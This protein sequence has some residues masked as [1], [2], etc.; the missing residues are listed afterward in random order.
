MAMVVT[1]AVGLLVAGC[2]GSTSPAP[3]G[4]MPATPTR[5][6]S[7]S[8]AAHRT[9]RFGGGLWRNMADVSRRPV[10]HRCGAGCGI[11]SACKGRKAVKAVKAWTVDLSGVV[12]GQPVVADGRIFAATENNR[13]VA[14][15]PGDGRVQWSVSLGAPLTDVDAVAGCG[16]IDP[17]G[18]T[19]TPVVDTRSHVVYVVGEVK[20]NDEGGVHHQL[21]GLDT[22]HR[23]GRRLGKCR[24]PAAGRRTCRQPAAAHL[25]RTRQR[26]GL[27]R[28]RRQYRRL[29]PLP[30]LAGRS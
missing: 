2:A 7:A 30:R 22:S 11:R 23:K 5:G 20:D 10:A 9:A 28:L 17:L 19:S 26:A 16:N 13:V 21:E 15:D 18:I 8:S 25:A 3:S 1:P 24:P 12:H 6:S 27:C 29:R 14:L 4:G